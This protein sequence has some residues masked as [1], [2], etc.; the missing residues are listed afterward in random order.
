M[1]YGTRK[2]LRGILSSKVGSYSEVHQQASLTFIET[3]KSHKHLR[4]REQP[5]EGL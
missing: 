5:T 4:D 3:T 1:R 2:Q